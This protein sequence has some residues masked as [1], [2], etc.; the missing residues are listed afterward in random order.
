MV[1]PS[2]LRDSTQIVLPREALDGL[3]AQLDEQF[4][5]TIVPETEA[6]YRIIGSPVVIKDVNEFLAKRGVSI[7]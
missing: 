1:T 6:T 3:D 4:T 5:V 2:M 7:R